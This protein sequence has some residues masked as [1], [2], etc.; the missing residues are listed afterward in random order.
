MLDL[1]TDAF[2]HSAISSVIYNDCRNISEQTARECIDTLIKAGANVDIS[3][4]QGILSNSFVRKCREIS[5]VK[6]DLFRHKY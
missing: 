2:G 6:F 4:T 1:K 3:D 5:T